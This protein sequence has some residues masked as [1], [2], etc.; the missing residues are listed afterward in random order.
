MQYQII[1]WSE[2][3]ENQNLQLKTQI[4][5]KKNMHCLPFLWGH[6]THGTI[7]KS[8]STLS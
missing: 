5:R 8:K 1:K 6:M 4:K 3:I 2:Q 7:E